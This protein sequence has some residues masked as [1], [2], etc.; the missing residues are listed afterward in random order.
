MPVYDDVT[1]VFRIYLFSLK[2]ALHIIDFIKRR[3]LDAVFVHILWSSLGIKV[4]KKK[5]F[6]A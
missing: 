5:G 6:H 2:D 3:N 1:E 4:K